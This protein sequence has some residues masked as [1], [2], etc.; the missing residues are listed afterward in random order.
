LIVKNNELLEKMK[1]IEEEDN[2]ICNY[3]KIQEE[4]LGTDG[5]QD[6]DSLDEEDTQ[7]IHEESAD[8]DQTESPQDEASQDTDHYKE[9]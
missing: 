5:S 2:N 1:Q 3:E 4:G 6:E 7:D 9:D 8:T